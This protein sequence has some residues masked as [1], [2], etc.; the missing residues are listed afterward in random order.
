MHKKEESVLQNAPLI[1][2][3]L[4]KDTQV[5]VKSSEK[6]TESCMLLSGIASSLVAQF[7]ETRPKTY[8]RSTFQTRYKW[9]I[10]HL[11]KWPDYLKK[12]KS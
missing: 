8:V 2:V 9:A 5:W 10:Q 6:M 11:K 12:K 3:I 4:L 7:L 1:P